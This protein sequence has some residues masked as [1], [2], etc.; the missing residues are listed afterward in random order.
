MIEIVNSDS[1]VKVKIRG[2]LPPEVFRRRPIRCLFM[3]PLL[4]IVIGGSVTLVMLPMP[5]YAAL[6]L[7]VVV[8]NFHASMLFLGHEIGHGATVRSRWLQRLLVYPGCALFCLSPYLWFIWHNG[9]HHGYTNRPDQDPDLFGTLDNFLHKRPV[10]RSLTKAAPGS[11]YWPSVLYLFIFFTLQAQSVLWVKSKQLPGYKGLN[12]KRA[13]I[14]SVALV[15]FWIGICVMTGLHGTLFVVVIPMMVA[16]FVVLSYI[17][18]N[19]ML[20][21]LSDERDTLGTTMSVTTFK[22]LDRIHFHF[23]HHVEHHLFP[24]MCSS[25]APRVRETLIQHFSDCYLA[26]PHWRAFI[27]VFQTP[28]IYDGPQVLVEP[29]SGR[30]KDIPSVEAALRAHQNVDTRRGR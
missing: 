23:S 30:R 4:G 10:S 26:P 28:R 25:M 21:P 6:V 18:T 11:G 14:D 29:Y 8:G 3:I 17:I 12:R 1:L 20:R 5:W 22:F 24:T 19:H 27:M 7:S 13:T 16:N 9:S 15:V 2:E